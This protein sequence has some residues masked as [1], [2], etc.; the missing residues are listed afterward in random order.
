MS[1]LTPQQEAQLQKELLTFMSYLLNPSN[2]F[3]GKTNIQTLING[4][5]DLNAN[6]PQ[7]KML[8]PTEAQQDE[9]ASNIAIKVETILRSKGLIT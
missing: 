4:L 3:F 6:L 8:I 5:T 9:V 1:S 7:M 2:G